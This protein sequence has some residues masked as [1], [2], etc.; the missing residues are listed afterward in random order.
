MLCTTTRA[1]LNDPILKILSTSPADW[2]PTQVVSEVSGNSM[3]E[4]HQEIPCKSPADMKLAT[5]QDVLH[6]SS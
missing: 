4:A 3:H 6:D 1:I 5:T 2:K